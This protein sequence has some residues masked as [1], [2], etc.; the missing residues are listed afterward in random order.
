MKTKILLCALLLL[1]L[2]TTSVQAKEAR[3][4]GV[5]LYGETLLAQINLYRQENGLNALRFD[6]GLNKLAQTHS[7]EMFQQKRM[8]HSN[9]NQRFERADSRLCVENVG[10]NYSNPLKMFDAWRLS[11]GHD[12]NMLKEGINKAG[13]S[14]V[15][16][17][18]T[19][20]ACK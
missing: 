18:V 10:W 8:G 13:I 2:G 15:G 3:F 14:E 7:F 20:F 16:D 19:F 11:R 17:Y 1:A 6:A 4:P 12:E 5:S 9:F